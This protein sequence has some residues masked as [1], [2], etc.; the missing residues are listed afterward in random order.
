MRRRVADPA[1]PVCFVVDSKPGICLLVANVCGDLGIA[2]HRFE[3][4]AAMI[5]AA[6]RQAPDV[7]F[8]EPGIDGRDG[9]D[10]VPAL[11][12]EGFRCP[13]QLMSGLNPVLAEEARRFGERKGLTML[14]VLEKPF[15]VR[16]CG[17]SSSSSGC[18]AT[19][20]P[21]SR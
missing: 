5:E 17:R 20:S 15:R 1:E 2:A 6:R 11:A 10:I 7:I 4:L 16:R 3:T 21:T 18:A 14:P 13:I 12:A 9:E 19:R 8:I